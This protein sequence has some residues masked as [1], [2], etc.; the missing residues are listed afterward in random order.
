MMHGAWCMVYGAWRI[1]DDPHNL[2]QGTRLTCTTSLRGR[3][4]E[5]LEI[6]GRLD[7]M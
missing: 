2:H 4:C 6:M 7:V 5:S 3:V 1:I